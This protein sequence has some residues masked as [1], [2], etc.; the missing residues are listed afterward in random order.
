MK[1]AREENEGTILD[2]VLQNLHEAST[3]Q[4]MKAGN[5]GLIEVDPVECASTC[6]VNSTIG[7][8]GESSST[9]VGTEKR[10][11]EVH[12]A[13]MGECPSLFRVERK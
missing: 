8:M 11:C 5:E 2:R 13:T 10:E 7:I 6:Y 1:K 4:Y 12:R 3:V 9:V